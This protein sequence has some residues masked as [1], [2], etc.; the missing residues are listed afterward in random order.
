MDAMDKHYIEGLGD[1][2]LIRGIMMYGLGSA[3]AKRLAYK[4]IVGY[5]ALEA[6]EKISSL[7]DT[8]GPIAGIL[9]EYQLEIN[10]INQ[11]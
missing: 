2:Q 1:E 4:L 11:D 3:Y 8:Y 9:K 6:L 10:S 7:C 5:K